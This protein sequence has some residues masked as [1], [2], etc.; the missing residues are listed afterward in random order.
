MMADILPDEQR[1]QGFGILRVVANLSVSIGPAIGGL[2]AGYSYMILFVTDFVVS[3]ITAFI[4]YR[5]IP[6][7]KPDNTSTGSHKTESF[8]LT[9][10][11]YWRV[12]K[13]VVFVIVVLLSL[14][15]NLVYTQM[16]STLSVFLRDMHGVSAQGYGYILT[17]NALLVV[18]M[19][20]WITRKISSYKPM[21]LMFVGNILYAIG[22]AMYGFVD[23]YWLFLLAMVIITVGEMISSPIMQSL[24]ARFAP[25][26]MRG[27]YMA[28]F[29]LSYGTA[30][31]IGP[32]AAGIIIDNHD[33]NLVWYAGGII[34]TIS[35][36]GYLLLQ[37]ATQKKKKAA[38]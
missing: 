24:V 27:R 22:F 28:I 1:A 17:L 13:D 23:L 37:A 2:L 38:N 33:P 18:V 8:L 20:F 26:D 10:S 35:A 4:V 32:L 29:N 14:L 5:K 7:T 16:N 21:V 30:N 9:M 19:Q 6:E 34:C 31:A 15:T 3:M 11:G 36:F 25:E 12:L